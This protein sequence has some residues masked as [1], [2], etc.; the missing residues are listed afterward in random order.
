VTAAEIAEAG[1]AALAHGDNHPC[2]AVVVAGAAVD[3][4]AAAWHR[5]KTRRTATGPERNYC[6]SWQQW[7]TRWGDV[8]VD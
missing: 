3:V 1:D 5:P 2:R 4:A 7:P 6:C 8:P